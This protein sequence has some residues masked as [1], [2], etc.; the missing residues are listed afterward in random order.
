MDKPVS[1]LSAINELTQSNFERTACGIA[2]IKAQFTEEESSA[3]EK[4]IMETE[5]STRK[6]S[7]MLK[8]NNYLIGDNTIWKHRKKSC[9]CFRVAQ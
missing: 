6:I 8:D 7:Q 2:K 1:L 5:I 9:P 3:L 4:L